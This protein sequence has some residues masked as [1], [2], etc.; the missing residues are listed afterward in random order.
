[1][2]A[3]L[4]ACDIGPAAI[5][6]EPGPEMTP[7]KLKPEESMISFALERKGDDAAGPAHAH[8]KTGDRLVRVHVE[9]GAEK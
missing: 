9:L 8:M 4:N 1:M 6:M 3:P 2:L 7:A 5:S